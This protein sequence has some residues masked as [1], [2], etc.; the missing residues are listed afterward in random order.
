[1]IKIV[2]KGKEEIN[3][4]SLSL[5]FAISETKTKINAVIRYLYMMN[6]IK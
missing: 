6:V 3:A 1:M 4:P 2:T 5:R